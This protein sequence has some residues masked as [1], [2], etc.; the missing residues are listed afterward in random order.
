MRDHERSRIRFTSKQL[1]IILCLV[2]VMALV[3]ADQ[4]SKN[5][6]TA[7]LDIG[8]SIPVIRNVFHFTLV[9]NTGIAFGLFKNQ[10]FSNYFFWI[11]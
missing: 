9:H 2:I 1:Q 5:F 7:T 3:L 10:G 8:E 6:F 11:M 4:V